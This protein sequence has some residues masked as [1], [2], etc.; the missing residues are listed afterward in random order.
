[1]KLQL[2][3]LGIGILVLVLGGMGMITFA[4]NTSAAMVNGL[5]FGVILSAIVNIVAI[6]MAK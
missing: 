2:T 6:K 1:M 3:M 5:V 4:N